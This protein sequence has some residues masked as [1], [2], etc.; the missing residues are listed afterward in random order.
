MSY[1]PYQNSPPSDKA[2][3][4]HEFSFSRLSVWA[5]AGIVIACILA[6]VFIFSTTMVCIFRKGHLFKRVSN[7]GPTTSSTRN[8][9]YRK[10]DKRLTGSSTEAE[11]DEERASR[12]EI[13]NQSGV[14]VS[15]GA[16][17][18][19]PDEVALHE[20]GHGHGKRVRSGSGC[21]QGQEDVARGRGWG[22]GRGRERNE[23]YEQEREQKPSEV[24][25]E[26]VEEAER[27]YRSWHGV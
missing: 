23:M 20:Y 16:S 14:G 7:Y 9:E 8:N 17:V 18:R 4:L 3:H 11:I 22:R 5:R 19:R 15:F 2:K 27:E 26:E 12:R 1:P 10:V 6:F 21:E 13:H 24:Q 25:R